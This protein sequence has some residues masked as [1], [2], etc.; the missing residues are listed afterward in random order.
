MTLKEL[1][2]SLGLTQAELGRLVGKSGITVHNWETG[3]TM[4]DA[5]SLR[6]ICRMAGVSMDDIELKEAKHEH[7]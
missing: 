6:T 2:K 7:L 1:K 5:L 4:I 3:V